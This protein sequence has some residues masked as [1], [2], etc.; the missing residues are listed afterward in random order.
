MVGLFN[1]NG[2][3]VF[4]GLSALNRGTLRRKGG[5][6]TFHFNADSS[7]SGFLFRTSHSANQLS[8][9]GAVSSWCEELA[10]RIPSRNELTVDKYVAKE[11]EHLLTN[12]KP[13]EVNSLVQTPRS[14]NE[15]SGNRLRECL[16]RFGTLEK[17]I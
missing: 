8:T 10:Q 4:K 7:N 14:D 3:P 2:H 12:V 1:A 11:N 13:Q 16:Q 15:A 9:Y 6:C 5:R 17:D